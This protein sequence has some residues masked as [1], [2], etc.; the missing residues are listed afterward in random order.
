MKK[1]SDF[2]VRTKLMVLVVSACLAL[3]VVGAVG[4][5]GM[6]S[7]NQ[8][9]AESNNSMEQTALL[10]Q[11]KSDFLTMRLDLVYMMALKDEV[12]LREKWT[13]FTAKTSAVRDSLK[14]FQSHKLTTH[15]KD[16]MTVF[17]DGFEQYVTTGTKLGEMLLAAHAANNANALAEAIKYG[18]GVVDPPVQPAG[19]DRLQTCC[20]K[21]QEWG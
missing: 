2:Q 21:Y 14:K 15:E 11:M 6:R 3:A 17:K 8:S 4:L 5:L 13:D 1:W 16:G 12:K 18:T 10:G 7:A 20:R 19:R 9:L